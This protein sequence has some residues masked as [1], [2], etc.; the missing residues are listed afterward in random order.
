MPIHISA[1]LYQIG[2]SVC[3]TDGWCEAVR[4]YVLLNN[5]RPLIFDAGSHLHTA[6]LMADLKCL[7]G[8]MKPSYV[9]LT[10]TELPHTGNMTAIRNAWPDIEFVVSSGI[11]PHVE[12]PWWVKPASVRFGYPGTDEIFAGRRISFLDAMLKDQPGTHWMYDHQTGTLFTADALDI[13][14][15]FQPISSSTMK[16]KMGS[17]WTGFADT[18]KL[19]SDFSNCRQQTG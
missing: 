3:G 19:H 6:P 4:V 15:L 18:M 7:I 14:S 12:L 9:F 5:G 17:P 11:L 8:D 13:C 10:H 2:E 1:D 16:W